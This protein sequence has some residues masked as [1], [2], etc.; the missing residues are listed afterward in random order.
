MSHIGF[1]Q[2]VLDHSHVRCQHEGEGGPVVVDAAVMVDGGG[3]LWGTSGESG[4]VVL[5]R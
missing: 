2:P 1:V 5:V 4:S 3:G